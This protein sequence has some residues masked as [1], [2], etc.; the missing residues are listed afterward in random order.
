MRE[1]RS[2]VENSGRTTVGN[3][4]HRISISSQR[5]K[6]CTTGKPVSRASNATTIANA[7]ARHACQQSSWNDSGRSGDTTHAGYPPRGPLSGPAAPELTQGVIS[8]MDEALKNLMKGLTLHY[9]HRGTV[10]EAIDQ[11]RG[12]GVAGE[13]LEC[14]PGMMFEVTSAA[15]AIFDGDCGFDEVV[16]E[17]TQRALASGNAEDFGRD[18]A[19]ALV[20][21]TIEFFEELCIE[22]GSETPLP[23]LVGP[24]YEYGTK[25][26]PTRRCTGPA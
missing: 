16:N 4:R 11:G 22:E 5:R 21:S 6:R 17:L 10:Q 2:P 25:E 24:W 15:G 8:T 23:E 20:R 9:L 19:A 3:D 18:D 14:L 7:S 12:G 26:R 13:L 1:S